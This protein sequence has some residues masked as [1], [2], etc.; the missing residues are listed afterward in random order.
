MKLLA[1]DTYD[2]M[3]FEVT[4]DGFI[5]G[6]SSH[7]SRLLNEERYAKVVKALIREVLKLRLLLVRFSK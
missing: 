4:R 2:V 3:G 6:C 7:D 5:V 1:G